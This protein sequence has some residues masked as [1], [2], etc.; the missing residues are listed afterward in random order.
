MKNED[1]DFGKRRST[2]PRIGRFV[3][4]TVV[5][6]VLF[7]ILGVPLAIQNRKLVLSLANKH[8]GLAPIRI[9]LASIEAG[10][11]TP[12]KVRDLRL[13][14]GNGAELV[15]IGEVETELTLI[16]LLTKYSDLKKITVKG[17]EL[18]VQVQPGTTNLEQALQPL[19]AGTVST[20]VNSPQPAATINPFTGRVVLVD[21]VVHATDSVDQTSWDLVLNKVDIPIP[22]ASQPIPP[23]TLLG[24]LRQTKAHPGEVLMGGQFQIR[25]EPLAQIDSQ[26]NNSSLGPVKMTVATTGLPLHWISLVKRRL[27]DLPVDHLTGL[28]TIQTELEVHNN[29]SIFARIHTAQIDSLQVVA[30]RLVG[31]KGASLNQVRLAGNLQSSNNRLKAEGLILQT[32]VGAVTASADLP[33]EFSIPTISEPWL[34]NAEY[35]IEANIDLARVVTVAPDLIPVQDQVQLSSGRA[36]LRAFQKFSTNPN[37]PPSSTIK[38]GLGGLKAN[39]NGTQMSWEEAFS[40]VVNISS[41]PTGQPSLKLDC[42]SEFGLIKGEGDLIRGS[43]GGSFDLEA[44]HN[45]LSQWVALPM[46]QVRGS[47]ECQVAWQQ[48]EGNRLVATGGVRTTPISIR[49]A[50]GELKEPKWDGNFQVV[51]RLDRGKIIQIDRAN[52]ELKADSELLSAIV[53]EPVSLV[54]SAPGTAG[55]PPA[56]I[57]MKLIGDLAGWQ[58]RGQLLAGIDLGILIGGQCDLD[59]KGIVDAASV[60]IQDASL[61]IKSFQIRS[62]EMVF[63]EPELIATFKGAANSRDITKLKIDNLLV[64]ALSFAVQANDEA[65]PSKSFGRLGQAAYRVNPK[66]LLESLGYAQGPDAI[67]VE[68]D[69]TGTA[70]WSLDAELIQWSMASKGA[71]LK[72]LQNQSNNAAIL[73]S[74]LNQTNGI[75]RNQLWAEPRVELIAEGSYELAKGLLNV[76]K[77]QMMTEWLAYG[78]VAT[79]QQANGQTKVISKGQIHYDAARV[80]E[81]IKPWTGSYLALSGRKTQPLDIQWIS[82]DTGTGTWAEALQASSQIGWE[83]ANVLGIPVGPADIPIVVRNGHLLTQAD[84]PVSQGRLRW[85]LDGDIGSNPIQITQQPQTVIDNVAITPQMCQGWLRFVAPILADVTSVQGNLSLKIDEAVLVPTSLMNQTVKGQLIVHGANVG[86]GPLADQLIG[87]VQQIRNFKRGLGAAEP[88]QSANWL[89]M[90]QQDIGFN[91]QNGRVMHRDMRFQAGEVMLTTN[92]SVGIDGSLELNATV[93]IQADWLERASALSSLAGQSIVIPI[94][95][96]I[97]KPQLDY[98]SLTSLA[99]QVASTALRG[100]AQKQIDKGLNKL[101]G[102]ISNQLQ[103]LQQG[104]QQMQQGVQNNLPQFPNLPNFQLPGFGGVLPFGQNTPPQPPNVPQVPQ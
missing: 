10:W 52:L 16:N 61:D 2:K 60:E 11:F 5:V 59:A 53:L 17:A 39:V 76:T 21:A 6:L 30:P 35:E 14:D 74:T 13:I 7:A 72:I 97:Q 8:A 3:I 57:Q 67:Y 68:G 94:R 77:T 31:D 23:M 65:D 66:Q 92:G 19:L 95:G 1:A 37:L 81:K 36:N 29:Q 51:T 18:H 99:Q 20:D 73:V 28:A 102:P 54:P 82:N 56:G 27:P 101:L 69:V 79:V 22:T 9:D 41:T 38:L 34:A 24:T 91:V 55:M 100:E 71:A 44:M 98:S 93:P 43:I 32:D 104:V 88:S 12:V 90:P 80:A 47:A 15:R 86:P 83:G 64:R 50:N 45:R 40:A 26:K 49:N 4:L 85:N 103:P 25:T 62:G 87:V 33:Y 78:G 48:D 46:Q 84:I 63:S 42:T 58:R 70:Q 89:H 96:T 75:P